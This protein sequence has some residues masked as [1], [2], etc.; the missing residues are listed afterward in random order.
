MNAVVIG[1]QNA[2]GSPGVMPGHEPGI[3]ATVCFISW[4]AGPSPA[5]TLNYFTRSILSSPPI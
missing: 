3:R 5:M 1:D 2:H 4:M